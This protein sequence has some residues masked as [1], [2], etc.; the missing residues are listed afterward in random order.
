MMRHHWVHRRRQDG[1]CKQCGKVKPTSFFCF[2][3]LHPPAQNATVHSYNMAFLT[4]SL[5]FR[6]DK[7]IIIIITL[8]C[9]Y[10]CTYLFY[11]FYWLYCIV[12]FYSSIH[13]FSNCCNYA[14]K[15]SSSLRGFVLDLQAYALRMRTSKAKCAPCQALYKLYFASRAAP[16]TI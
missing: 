2:S 16:E 12:L 7:N 10:V 14:N 4:T 11:L 13:L 9:L 3:G 8:N 1:K 5:G 6:I 15:S